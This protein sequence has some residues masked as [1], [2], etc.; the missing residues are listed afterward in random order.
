MLLILACSL[1]SSEWLQLYLEW[2]RGYCGEN[3]MS[4]QYLWSYLTSSNGFVAGCVRGCISGT[5]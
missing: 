4:R 3:P 2:R 1:E 5:L